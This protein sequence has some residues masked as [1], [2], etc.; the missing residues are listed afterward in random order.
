MAQLTQRRGVQGGMFMQN[1]TDPAMA[2]LWLVYLEGGQWRAP[3]SPPE[4]AAA[5]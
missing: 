5:D 2:H 4:R 1:A 3:A